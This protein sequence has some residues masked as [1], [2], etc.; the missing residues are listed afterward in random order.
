MDCRRHPADLVPLASRDS[1]VA[2]LARPLL[3]LE[4][5]RRSFSRP[6][7]D[8]PSSDRPIQALLTKSAIA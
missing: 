4:P 2:E 5:G 8:D 3:G 7:G 6:R 1:A